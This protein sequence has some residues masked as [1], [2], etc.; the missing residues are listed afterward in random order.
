MIEEVA[1]QWSV[2]DQTINECYGDALKRRSID[3]ANNIIQAL[4]IAFE[5]KFG[6]RRE[7]QAFQQGRILALSVDTTSKGSITNGKVSEHG[8]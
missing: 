3:F 6:E 7:D 2:E 4:V 8:Q 1:Q 5:G